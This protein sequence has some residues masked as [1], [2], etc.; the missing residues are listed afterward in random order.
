[1]TDHYEAIVYDLDGTLVRLAVDWA[2]VREEV[3]TNLSDR[4]IE[5][6]DETLWDLFELA[7]D[8]Q[9]EELVMET[10]ASFERDG[11][12]RSTRLSTADELP[13]AVPVGVC[14]LNCVAACRIALE[15]HEL[16]RHVDAIVGRDSVAT[17]KPDPEPLLHTIEQLG[18]DPAETVFIGDSERDEITADRA[19]TAFEYVSDRMDH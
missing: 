16:D 7:Q 14:S 19:G 17:Q 6:E 3:R 9:F 13:H 10:I 5:S 18:V 4:G 12:R 8:G 11:A 15:R 2:E 1:M